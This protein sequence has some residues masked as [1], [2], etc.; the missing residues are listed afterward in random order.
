[1]T[2]LFFSPPKA[3]ADYVLACISTQFAGRTATPSVARISTNPA[4]VPLARSRT[5]TM[6]P[7]LALP[8]RQVTDPLMDRIPERGLISVTFFF[9][10]QHVWT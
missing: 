4:A 2:L 1:M 9:S 10:C 7:R 6:R 8:V 3:A 5:R